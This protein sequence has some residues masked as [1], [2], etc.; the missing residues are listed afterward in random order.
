MRTTGLIASFLLFSGCLSAAEADPLR[1][2]EAVLAAAAQATSVPATKPQANARPSESEVKTLA[3]NPQRTAAAWLALAAR[4]GGQRT[5]HSASAEHLV[6]ALPPPS[7][8]SALQVGLRELSAQPGNHPRAKRRAA[9]WQLL[10]AALTT[11]LPTRLAA[12][13]NA[14]ATLDDDDYILREA[15]AYLLNSQKNR[16]DAVKILTQRLDKVATESSPSIEVP[17]LV[18]LVGEEQALPLVR[19][20]LELPFSDL[21]VRGNKTRA[22]AVREALARLA[23]LKSPPWSL[24]G[25]ADSVALF[26]ALEAKFPTPSN[27]GRRGGGNYQFQRA[28]ALYVAQL[29]AA[30]RSAEAQARIEKAEAQ[31]DNLLNR[32]PIRELAD[33][34]PEEL[35]NLLRNLLEKQPTRPLWHTYA[36]LAAQLGRAGELHRMIRT[37]GAAAAR[38]HQLVNLLL[39]ADDIE[40][41]LTALRADLH[42][43]PQVPAAGVENED[44][45]D[46][47][48]DR[49]DPAHVALQLLTLGSVLARADF[50][51]EAVSWYEKPQ[52]H[53]KENAY[54][55]DPWTRT[56][57]LF[58][59]GRAGLAERLLMEELQRTNDH[60]GER[61]NPQVL[62]SLVRLYAAA[63]RP[64]DAVTILTKSERWGASD[65]ADISNGCD[66]HEAIPPLAV[67]AGQA[68]L[69]TGKSDLA[70]ACALLALDQAPTCDAAYALLLALPDTGNPDTGAKAILQRLQRQDA[71]EER[72]L[73]WSAQ[74]AVNAKSWPEAEKLARQAMELDPSDGDQG[75]GDRMR[76]RAVLAEAL[77][78]QGKH[79]EAKPLRIALN[80]IRQGER[81]DVYSRAGLA[82]R[83]AA[84]YEASVDILDRTYCVQ[85][86]LAVTL[87]R[88]GR[89]EEAAK[90]FRRAFELMPKA[91]GRRESHCFGCEGVF[92]SNDAK[93]IAEEVFTKLVA[94]DPK[95]ARHQYLL[96]YVQ[97]AQER[98]Q[99]AAASFRAAIQ[100]D[101]EYYSAI[102]ALMKLE[103]VVF[104]PIAERQAWT[105][106][107]IRLD[108]GNQHRS[109]EASNV[110]DVAWFHSALSAQA[111]FLKP[112]A[113]P[114]VL[115]L[116]TPTVAPDR[117]Q[118]YGYVRQQER[119]DGNTIGR[120]IADHPFLK[121]ASQ[122]LDL[123]R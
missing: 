23:S 95:N 64:A 65:L 99:L 62:S 86:R 118:S 123:D 104:L 101:P 46:L 14:K 80:A 10:G 94:N 66:A 2:A 63:G 72:P 82:T 113:P 114:T 21:E 74:L 76:A 93:S 90:H 22:L 78:A 102:H 51:A 27:Q 67:V 3:D 121:A 84:A 41:V 69:A 109:W 91:F 122:M 7:E 79:E 28:E 87:A 105:F 29:T 30:G 9:S 57:L 88:L 119:R 48:H 68:L 47:N 54:Q 56:K 55:S 117:S 17:D 60:S 36:Q 107:L 106:T 33:Q 32:L 18:T 35:A 71:L 98:P 59:A 110:E 38:Q 116:A 24:I 89:N 61:D 43:V 31:G 85:S 97:A 111:E 5:E 26:E 50:I 44:S 42:P 25:G 1:G 103:E 92:Q 15:D 12:L 100:L 75:P 37:H 81:A 8:W 49:S 39:A 34:R 58:A 83:A 108:P 13:T 19:R 115:A 45:I 70:W 120:Y 73:I 16:P 6:A 112:L 53:S 4:W 96:G 40:A 11:D 52:A 20:A 77:E